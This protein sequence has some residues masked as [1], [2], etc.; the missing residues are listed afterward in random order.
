MKKII[1]TLTLSAIV[2]ITANLKAQSVTYRVTKNDPFDIKNFSCAIDP[3]WVDLNG[4]NGYAYGWGLRADHM[5]GKTLLINLDFRQ[6]FGTHGFDS[7]NNNTRNYFCFEGGLGLVISHKV[8]TRNVP[9]ILS[10]SSHTSGGVTYTTTYSI[11]GGVPAKIRTII[12][13]R[14][15]VNM[16]GNSIDYSKNVDDSLLTFKSKN[17]DNQFSYSHRADS[18]KYNMTSVSS[19]GAYSSTSIYAGFCF[20]HIR[21][22]I[23]DVDGWGIR[24][25]QAYN[26][27]YIDGMFAPV[28]LIKDFQTQPMVAT[29]GSGT[30][31]LPGETF[32]VKYSAVSHFGW[33]MGWS[34]RQPKNQGFSYKFEFGQRP[35]LKAKD[36]K[37]AVNFRNWYMMF[38][39][40]LYIPL[41]LKPIVQEE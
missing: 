35:G 29:V 8:R 24:S 36:N 14:G 6:G 7:R 17:T 38:T 5:M 28:L 15:G 13:F 1:Y 12:A 4:Q 18:V 32:D 9:I 26:D 41:K 23:V 3:L 2:A 34:I 31:T 10:S 40:G 39:Y 11:R 30:V 25:N 22:L 20:R 33:R 16:M 37:S 27:F 21:Q 19:F